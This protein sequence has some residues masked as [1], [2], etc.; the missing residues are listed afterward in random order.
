MTNKS[1]TCFQCG[2]T[3]ETMGLFNYT[4]CQSCKSK[5]RLFTDESIQKY[6]TEYKKSKDHS[7]ETEMQNRLEILEKDYINKK[8]KLLHVLERIRKI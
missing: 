8:I 2:T 5:L 4:I 3:K 1:K 7:L 6:I